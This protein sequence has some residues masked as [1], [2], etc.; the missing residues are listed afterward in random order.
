MTDTG[1]EL[2]AFLRDDLLDFRLA[3]FIGSFAMVAVGALA[4]VY[5]TAKY[6]LGLYCTGV[7]FIDPPSCGVAYSHVNR[8]MVALALVGVVGLV[9]SVY[10][11]SRGDG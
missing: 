4:G 5:L 3:E 6:L 7:V 11:E 2:A 9:L 1:E 8:V 10:L